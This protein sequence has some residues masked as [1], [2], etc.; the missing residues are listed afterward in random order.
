MFCVPSL[1]G[2]I[3]RS[4]KNGSVRTCLGACLIFAASLPT[5]AQDQPGLT[6]TVPN[7]PGGARA[8]ALEPDDDLAPISQVVPRTK[9]ALRENER[10]PDVG[11]EETITKHGKL[12]LHNALGPF[13]SLSPRQNFA[14]HPLYI[15]DPNLE[16]CGYT[17]GCCLQ[18]IV[19]GFH[20]FTSVALLP[21]KMLVTPPCAYV[22]PLPECPRCYRY[23]CYENYVGP[24]PRI[25]K[26]IS[27]PF[28]SRRDAAQS[29]DDR[30][31]NSKT[32]LPTEP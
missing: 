14:F 5:L 8:A 3:C 22:Y 10:L 24:V 26:L 6:G 2:G 11:G 29:M 13:E 21:C 19:S 27:L 15:E 32:N 9:I 7:G 4:P 31:P 30:Q 20:F 18:P 25:G 1:S 23:G 12:Y 17:Y 16:R 28:M